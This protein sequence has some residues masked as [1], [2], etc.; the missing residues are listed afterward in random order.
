[1]VPKCDRGSSGFVQLGMAQGIDR[2]FRRFLEL[3]RSFGVAVKREPSLEEC[4]NG[5]RATWL[6]D[7][8]S[9]GRPRLIYSDLLQVLDSA[10]LEDQV[11]DAAMTVLTL[12][13]PHLRPASSCCAAAFWEPL[14]TG[15]TKVLQVVNTQAADPDATGIVGSHWVAIS[16]LQEAP[17]SFNMAV[18]DSLNGPVSTNVAEVIGNLCQGLG[19][20]RTAQVFQQEDGHSCGPLSIANSVALAL[21]LDPGYQHNV[22]RDLRPHLAA[23][24]ASGTF[25][26]FPVEVA[27]SNGPDVGIPVGGGDATPSA[28]NNVGIPVERSEDHS[29]EQ[30]RPSSKD[31]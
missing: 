17:G 6:E 4:E 9:I 24:L 3:S 26:P 10:W 31:V 15:D 25:R 28:G 8:P 23:C 22:A 5:P 11:I 20:V 30:V 19:A 21:G 14:E 2:N 29:I 7:D 12:Q 1:M 18:Y 16:N 27:P 13:F